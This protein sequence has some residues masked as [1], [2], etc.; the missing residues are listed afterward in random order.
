MKAHHKEN[1][2]YTTILIIVLGIIAVFAVSASKTLDS[3]NT[4]RI[5]NW[6]LLPQVINVP[7]SKVGVREKDL[8]PCLDNPETQQIIARDAE[9]AGPTGTPLFYIFSKDHTYRMVGAIPAAM[10]TQMIDTLQAGRPIATPA[11]AEGNFQEISADAPEMA[12]LNLRPTDA[13]LNATLT[14]PSVTIIEYGDLSCPACKY[15]HQE[16]KKALSKE[17]TVQYIY[18]HHP[19]TSIHPDAQKQAEVA[20]CVQQLKG[21][22]AFWDF[23]DYTYKQ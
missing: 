8:A 9:E 18:R 16:L 6:S 14:N 23:V 20:V 2:I 5:G 19:L 7:L 10:L 15:A 22:K 11:E 1:T 21:Y 12:Y 13:R 3:I 17:T 4:P